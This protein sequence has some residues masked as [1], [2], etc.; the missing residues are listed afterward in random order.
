MYLILLNFV[1]LIHKFCTYI[2]RVLSMVKRRD[3]LG[4]MT[5]FM[6][7]TILCIFAQND[8]LEI[9]TASSS[10]LK[11]DNNTSPTSI[12]NI[13]DLNRQNSVEHSSQI[14]SQ[15]IYNRN[16]SI[17]TPIN[18]YTLPNI[19][20]FPKSPSKKK[21]YISKTIYQSCVEGTNLYDIDE[22]IIGS[23]EPPIPEVKKSHKKSSDKVKKHSDYVRENERRH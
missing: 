19:I 22:K 20:H 12:L 6:C 8:I 10:P 5:V 2:I 13:N 21:Q 16:L 15:A 1:F 3:M 23:F 14:K 18:N 11:L 7:S 17:H 9:Q 4:K